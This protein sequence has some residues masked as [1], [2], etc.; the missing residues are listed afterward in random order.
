MGADAEKVTE[1]VASLLDSLGDTSDQIADALRK[2]GITGLTDNVC[3][4]PVANFLKV[5]GVKNPQVDRDAVGLVAYEER[6][7]SGGP[8]FVSMPR[9][10]AAFI[11][12]F[13]DGMYDNLRAPE[14]ASA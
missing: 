4:C 10:V 6:D 11:A 5:H 3:D 7:G 1:I 9:P 13:D 8:L 12:A 14:S 2:R